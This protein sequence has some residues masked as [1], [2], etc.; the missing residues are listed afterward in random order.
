MIKNNHLRQLGLLYFGA[1]FVTAFALW[2]ESKFY[3]KMAGFALFFYNLYQ[4]FTEMYFQQQDE[5]EE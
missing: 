1:S 2:F 5:N 4:I 3:C